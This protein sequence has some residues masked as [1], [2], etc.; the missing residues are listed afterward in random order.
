MGRSNIYEFQ[1]KR[2]R[3]LPK[4]TNK[5][6]KENSRFRI[7]ILAKWELC[8]F[9]NG[10]PSNPI[11]NAKEEAIFYLRMSSRPIIEDSTAVR[12]AAELG[13][14][15]WFQVAACRAVRQIGRLC[16]RVWEGWDG[17]HFEL[18]WWWWWH[19]NLKGISFVCWAIHS[20]LYSVFMLTENTYP[21]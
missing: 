2:R 1:G 9:V 17:S 11:H 12:F 20:L 18:R 3:F 6:L 4:K 10:F 16:Q 8:V 14:C 15:G 5:I 19:W 7:L 21:D 13:E